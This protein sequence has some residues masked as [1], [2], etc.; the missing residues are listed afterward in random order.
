MDHS[1]F[2]FTS[3]VISLRKFIH[4]A[5]RLLLFW[6]RFFFVFLKTIQTHQVSDLPNYI[7]FDL[8]EILSVPSHCALIFDMRVLLINYLLLNIFL[9]LKFLEVFLLFNLLNP[10]FIYNFF[11]VTKHFLLGDKFASHE[12]I[13]TVEMI[14]S[15]LVDVVYP[16]LFLSSGVR[17]LFLLKGRYSGKLGRLLRLGRQLLYYL[18]GMLLWLNEWHV[19]PPRLPRPYSLL[20]LKVLLQ[21]F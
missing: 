13:D 16:F 12:W 21:E 18:L 5:Y 14:L 2:I 8:F 15:H 1:E 11:I 7:L 20:I 10:N 4:W 9:S 3:W 6:E 19:D 17:I